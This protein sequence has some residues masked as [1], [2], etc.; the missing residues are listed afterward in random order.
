MAKIISYRVCDVKSSSINRKVM[1]RPPKTT[2][3]KHGIKAVR[4]YLGEVDI[5]GIGRGSRAS[6]GS[7][8]LA[9]RRRLR[10]WLVTRDID[11]AVSFGVTLSLPHGDLIDLR[12][13][14]G[15]P[16][17]RRLLSGKPA[18]DYAECVRRFG[19]AFSRRFPHSGFV[20]R[21]ELQIRGVPHTHAIVKMAREDLRA[22]GCDFVQVS[23]VLRSANGFR[24]SMQRLYNVGL[25]FDLIDLWVN[26]VRQTLFVG[27]TSDLAVWRDNLVHARG[28]SFRLLEYQQSIVRYLVDDMSKHKQEQLGY[29]GCQWNVVGRRNWTECDLLQLD[30]DRDRIVL[31]RL[32][33]RC[34]RRIVKADCIFGNKRSKY[35]PAVSGVSYLAD[36]TIQKILKFLRKK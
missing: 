4:E 13:V 24:Q 28:F 1:Y 12:P 25:R 29:R 31:A 30:D 17:P 10:E 22:L 35:Y 32:V 11:G 5:S 36:D 20:W 15:P 14:F 23:D 21:N 6:D 34:R 8:S 27:T 16:S 19:I 26:A 33:G 3:Y 18:I 9:S 2:I 7:F